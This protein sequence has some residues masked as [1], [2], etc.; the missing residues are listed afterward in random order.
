M[1]ERLDFLCLG[2]RLL[3]PEERQPASEAILGCLSD[4][5][6]SLTDVMIV[7]NPGNVAESRAWNNGGANLLSANL[8]ADDIAFAYFDIGGDRSAGRQSISFANRL[9]MTVVALS[10]TPTVVRG[11]CRP[12]R[13]LGHLVAWSLETF[14][15]AVLA[16]G[17]ELDLYE[18]GN[19][20]SLARIA[21]LLPGDFRCV[22]SCSTRR[23]RRL[24]DALSK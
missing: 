3:S 22:L 15:H 20:T 13:L 4:L 11:R 7:R 23:V 21:E 6:P 16:C 17:P 2:D 19:E 14:D 9:G 5:S 18:A 10:L 8:S 12:E 24:D 1:G